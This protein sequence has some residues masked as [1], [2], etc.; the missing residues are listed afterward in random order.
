M[1]SR[2]LG[3]LPA[4]IVRKTKTSYFQAGRL[5]W[6]WSVPAAKYASQHCRPLPQYRRCGSGSVQGQEEAVM[7][8]LVARMLE[9][10][11]DA[12][13]TLH[14]SLK[15]PFFDRLSTYHKLEDVSKHIL[16]LQI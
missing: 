5:A 9:Y 12:R 8:D 1:M 16:R 2:I 13:I 10:D 7:L 6:D 3:D 14:E 15:H 11:P 4:H